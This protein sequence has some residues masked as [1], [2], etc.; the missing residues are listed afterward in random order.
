MKPEILVLTRIHPPTL[1]ELEREFTV[2]KLWTA[3]DPDAL[4]REVAGSVRGVVTNGLTGCSRRQIE[5]LPPLEI[6]ACF[7][8]PHGTVDLAAAR[9]RGVIV[10]NTPDSIT[11][12]VADVAMGLLIAV[13]RRICENDRF[14]R[15]GKWLAGLPPLGRELGGKT[16]GIVGLGR[17]G[18]GVARRA[19]ACG[20]TVCYHGP[21]P[22]PEIAWTYFS[23]LEALARRSDC[24]VV[25]CTLTPATRGLVNARVLDALGPAGFLVNVARGPI[26]DQEAL[27]AALRDKR[28]AGAALDV[29]WDEPRVPEELIGMDNVVLTPHIGSSTREVREARGAKV[30][31]NLRAHF[32]GKPVPH[33]FTGRSGESV[34]RDSTMFRRS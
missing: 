7:G 34:N 20:M 11:E 8:T 24:L 29:Y 32:A 14:V 33:P 25:A 5:A 19:S 9:E 4:V 15:A 16:C 30:L 28:I 13:M 6:I 27:I 17:I 18:N 12:S 22:K 2:H 21:R 31:A 3:A 23:D 26:V 1:A 10:T